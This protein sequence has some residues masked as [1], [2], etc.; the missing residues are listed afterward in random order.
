MPFAEAAY[1]RQSATVPKLCA[2]HLWMVVEVRHMNVAL[3]VAIVGLLTLVAAEWCGSW[4]R[5]KGPNDDP[6]IL[7]PGD[8]YKQ[9]QALAAEMANMNGRTA[10][11]LEELRLEITRTSL[12]VA[13]LNE[14]YE[15]LARV[16]QLPG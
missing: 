7:G 3:L 15:T 8:L 4:N 5:P 10:E 14:S 9:V 13:A 6:P 2:N 1:V 12:Q 16:M 11:E